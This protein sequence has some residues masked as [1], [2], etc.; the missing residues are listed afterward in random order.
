MEQYVEYGFIGPCALKLLDSV[1]IKPTECHAA[2]DERLP[3]VPW[4]HDHWAIRSSYP[5]GEI[6][7]AAHFDNLLN[8]LRPHFAELKKIGASAAPTISWV[9]FVGADGETP[10][11]VLSAS[12]LK[13]ICELGADLNVSLYVE[14]GQSDEA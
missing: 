8:L 7:A 13:D 4:R 1:P 9:V 2:G 3:G 10:N 6:N 5:E 11:G 14:N 12:I